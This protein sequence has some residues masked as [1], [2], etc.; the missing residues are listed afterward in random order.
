MNKSNPMEDF[1]WLEEA[2]KLRDAAVNAELDKIASQKL[3]GHKPGK[4]LTLEIK[5]HLAESMP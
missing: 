3:V 1:G 4:R 5:Q 2:R